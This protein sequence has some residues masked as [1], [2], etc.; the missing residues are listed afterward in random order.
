MNA[1]LVRIVAAAPAS[2]GPL[3]LEALVLYENGMGYVERRG[4]VPPGKV[5]ESALEPGQLDDALKALVVRGSSKG[6][7]VTT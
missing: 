4:V 1:L 3:P 6:G 2:S 5:A 7:A